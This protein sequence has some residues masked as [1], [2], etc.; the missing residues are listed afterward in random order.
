MSSS[1]V[2]RSSKA[3]GDERLLIT[4]MIPILMSECVC[5]CV[6]VCVCCVCVCVCARVNYSVM[7]S[8][9]TLCYPRD[10]SPSGSSIHGILQA[11][12]LE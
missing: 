7:Q 8:C 1:V 9:P 11:R 3:L 2:N 5:V 10:C 4:R 12:I 6:C